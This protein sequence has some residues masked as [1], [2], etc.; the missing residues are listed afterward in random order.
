MRPL[1]P[2]LCAVVSLGCSDGSNPSSTQTK[3]DAA[4]TDCGPDAT[5]YWNEP[6]CDKPPSG[7]AD[8]TV[9]V[10]DA[11]PGFYEVCA[12][13]GTVLQKSCGGTS[14]PFL[15]LGTGTCH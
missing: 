5:P 14:K 11:C 12:C 15:P 7:C 8:P 9:P 6:G 3:T 4:V 10:E 1:V 13:D 2:A